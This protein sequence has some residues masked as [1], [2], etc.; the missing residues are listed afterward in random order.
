MTTYPYPPNETF[1][2]DPSAIEYQL[3]WNDRFDSGEPVR[4][5]HFDYKRMPSTPADDATCG[6][7]TPSCPAASAQITHE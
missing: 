1:P 4:S 5:Y 6:V 2:D 7:A 3:N